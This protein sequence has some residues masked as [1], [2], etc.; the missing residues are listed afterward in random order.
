MEQDMLLWMLVYTAAV[1]AG[2]NF[3]KEAADHA[4]LAFR[5][6][7]VFYPPQPPEQWEDEDIPF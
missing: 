4:V 7:E 1:N 5:N 2:N 3:P 6:T